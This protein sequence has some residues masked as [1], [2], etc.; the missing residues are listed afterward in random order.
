MTNAADINLARTGF[1]VALFGVVLGGMMTG[2]QLELI[3]ERR[4]LK[5]EG[6]A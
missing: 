3:L 1:A 6:L 2:A 4:K 5:K